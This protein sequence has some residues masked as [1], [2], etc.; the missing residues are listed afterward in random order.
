MKKLISISLA[1]AAILTL[2]VGCTPKEEEKPKD[3]AKTIDIWT[4]V[5]EKVGADNFPMMMDVDKDTL[6]EY[7]GIKEEDLEEY[8]IK[9]PMINTRADEFFIAKVKDGKMEEVEKGI[10]KRKTDLEK[11]WKQ[12]LPDVYETVQN[13]K[14]TKSG[15]YIMFVISE[16]AADAVSIFEEKTK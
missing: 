6:M 12:Y 15:N 3:T 9:A 1:F 14:I 5:E 8:T 13:A 16:N 4:A 11:Q 2:F 10:E 7:Y